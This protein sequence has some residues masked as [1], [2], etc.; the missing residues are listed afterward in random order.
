[1]KILQVGTR[2]Y[3]FKPSSEAIYMEQQHKDAPENLAYIS[4]STETF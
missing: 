2:L 3:I 4:Y 1:M